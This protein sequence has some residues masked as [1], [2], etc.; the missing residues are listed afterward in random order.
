M[1]KLR[2]F[3]N[4]RCEIDE[5]KIFWLIIDRDGKKVNSLDVNTIKELDGVIDL[6]EEQEENI[7]GVAIKSGKERG[8]IAGADI[9]DFT[10]LKDVKEANTLV[11]NAQNVFNRLE[12]L[13]VPTVVLID[14]FCLGGGL[15]FSLACT[16]RIALD[17]PAVLIGLPE[18]KLGIH[19][20]WGGCVRLPKLIGAL[21]ALPLILTGRALKARKAKKLGIVDDV[22]RTKALLDKAAI[23]YLTKQPKPHDAGWLGRLSNSAWLRPLIANRVRAKTAAKANKE[24]YPA[25]FHVIDNWQAHGV[26]LQP[27]LDAEAKSIGECFLHPTGRQLIRAFF[28]QEEMKSLGRGSNF[29]ATHV[30]VIGA[31]VMGGD[32]AAFCAYKGMRVTLQDREAKYIAPAI[33]RAHKL[34]QR[35]FDHQRDVTAAM[36]RLIPDVTGA[37]VAKADVVIEAIFE[38]LEAKQA[39]YKALEPKLKEGALLATNTSSIPLE[40]LCKSLKKKD[41]LIGVHFF[42]PVAMMMLVE[43]VKGK[44]SAETEVQKGLAFVSQIGKLPLPV[45]SSPGFLINRILMPYLM[46]AVTLMEEGVPPAAIDKAAVDFGMPMGPI[47]LCDVVGLDVGL[48]VAETLTGYYGGEVPEKLRDLVERGYLGKKSGTGIYQWR[49]GKP[50]K[51]SLYQTG[52]VPNDLTDRLMLRMVNEA[53]ACL[54]EGVVDSADLLD[55]GMIFGTGFAP[56]RGGPIQYLKDEGAEKCHR[57]LAKLEKRHG[58]RFAAHKGWSAFLSDDK[59]PKKSKADAEL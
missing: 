51:V 33:A 11:K 56:F 59:K 55:G 44:N 5:Q 31:G 57:R 29:K 20:G 53:I 58:E 18:V 46:E 36:D 27:A 52:E 39:L 32:I 47:E 50:V 17:S 19:P 10:Q 9:T 7:I 25:P 45:A 22:V 3:K 8:F 43:V 23:Y 41:R 49:E 38:N 15:E 28:M 1:S 21:Q 24:H 16:Y 48:S 4:W 34:F 26:D 37:G 6:I 30:H 40:E 13:K 12:S 54:D 42:N 2:T 14:G 35:K